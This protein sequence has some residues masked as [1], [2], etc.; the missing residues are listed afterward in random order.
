MVNYNRCIQCGLNEE[1]ETNK[2]LILIIKDFCLR[3]L[4][5]FF[6]WRKYNKLTTI[7]VDYIKPDP[8]KRSEE[9]MFPSWKH[10]FF[11]KQTCYI[12]SNND[13][14]VTPHIPVNNLRNV[15]C[16]KFD[17]CP[18]KTSNFKKPLPPDMFCFRNQ[19][20]WPPRLLVI[21]RF[22]IYISWYALY[23][24]SSKNNNKISSFIT[25]GLCSQMLLDVVKF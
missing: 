23:S 3:F 11:S 22:T 9:T 2:Q 10:C 17:I 8:S 5:V 1:N 20:L 15:P 16:C 24:I 7:S 18:Q 12:W 21:C 6:E 25:H 19:V 13:S 14:Y 4:H